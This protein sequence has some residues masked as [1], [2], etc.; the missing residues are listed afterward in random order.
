MLSCPEYLS[1]N[2]LKL[3]D[4]SV[5]TLAKRKSSRPRLARHFSHWEVEALQDPKDRLQGRLYARLLQA[6]CDASSTHTRGI[7]RTAATLYK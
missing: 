5:T 3:S 7:F 1:K 2:I 6:L 4:D